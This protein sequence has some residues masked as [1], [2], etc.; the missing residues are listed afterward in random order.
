M[1]RFEL[2]KADY[3]LTQNQHDRAGPKCFREG[4]NAETVASWI[5][6]LVQQLVAA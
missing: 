5:P 3:S 4:L 6:I 2:R 1:D